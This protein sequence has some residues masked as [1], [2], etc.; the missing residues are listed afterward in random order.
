MAVCKIYNGVWRDGCCGCVNV[1]A[2]AHVCVCVSVS[3]C[4][5]WNTRL[6]KRVFVL[7]CAL[8]GLEGRVSLSVTMVTVNGL[9]RDV[10]PGDE[11][12]L[13]Q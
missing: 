6:Q 5:R 8:T 2:C 1:F 4:I 7:P 12:R 9:S 10:N 13:H 11:I 3:V